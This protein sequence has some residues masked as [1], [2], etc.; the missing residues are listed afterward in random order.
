VCVLPL[1]PACPA[2]GPFFHAVQLRHPAGLTGVSGCFVPNNITLGA[3]PSDVTGGCDGDTSGARFLVLTGPN[4]GGKSTL[5][6]QVCLAAILAQVRG[7]RRLV[8]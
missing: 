5:L 2:A 3:P 4:M 7:E 6:R 1:L 8:G